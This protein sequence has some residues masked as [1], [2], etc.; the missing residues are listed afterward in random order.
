M[1]STVGNYDER[2]RRIIKVGEYVASTG[3]STRATAKYFSENE[4]KISNYTVSE[5]CKEYQKMFPNKANEITSVIDQNREK[6]IKD[7][8]VVA[9]V[10][11]NVSYV[12]DDGLSL[13]EISNLT[14]VNYWIVYR[15]LTER[16]K[17]LDVDLYNKIKEIFTE[18]RNNNIKR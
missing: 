4:F 7:E 16:L 14:G 13:E 8:N 1:A 11:Q 15:D 10:M 12:L 2:L 9:R 18:N 3:S 17:S 5:Y 6:T